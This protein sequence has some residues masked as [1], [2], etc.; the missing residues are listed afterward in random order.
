V[1]RRHFLGLGVGG[2][3]AVGLG[4]F[5]G[6]G[7]G[8]GN[9]IKLVSSLP[10]TGSAKGQTDTIVNGIRLAI[11]EY[12]EI[13]GMKIEYL[14]KDDATAQAGEWEAAKEADN[15]REAIADKNVVAFIGPYNSGA[16]K[17]SMPI[18]NEAGLVQVSPACTWPGLTKKVPGDEKSGEPDIY[19]KSGTL[20]FCRVCPT[21]FVQGPLSAVFAKEVLKVGR[22]YIL[23]DKQLYGAGI[24]G[25]F[26]KK[27]KELGIEILGHQSIDPKQPNFKT[28]MAQV[29]SKKPQLLYFGGTSQS[30]GPQIAKDLKAEPGLGDCPMMCPD[31]CYE[32]AFIDGAGADVVNGRVYATIGGK[33]PSQLTG[34]GAEF[35]KKYKEKYPGKS[36]EAYA[37]YG[38]EAGKVVLEAV[39]KVGSKDRE[40]IRKEILATKDFTA[41]ALGKWS[42]DADGDTDLKVLTI[43]LI[44]GGKFVPKKTIEDT[45][46]KS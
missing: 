12:P 43:S 22:V 16:A 20:T 4:S 29:A 35:V 23:D 21:D 10:R 42:F 13:A 38:Y 41:G 27:A 11:D 7:K 40:A 24:A 1:D 14:D 15:A 31:G 39:K 36:I 19:K 8:N 30:G 34:P 46:P 5:V 18:L 6:C 26:E 17:A 2:A 33:D 9:T 25:L 32:D 37:V 45:A 28:L 3:A 44:E